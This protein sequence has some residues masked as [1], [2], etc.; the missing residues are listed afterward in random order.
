M[1]RSGRFSALVMLLAAPSMWGQADRGTIRGT[2]TDPA[3]SGVAQ[4][5]VVAV[6]VATGTQNATLSTES[7][8]YN[9]PALPAGLYR[10]Q[11]EAQGFKKLLRENVR[12]N[13]GVIV[14]LDLQFELGATAETIT[15]SAEAPQ[16]A[17]ESSDLR[18][19]INP[20]TFADL[21]L[22]S[23]TGRNPTGLALLS[24]GTR[25]GGNSAA[26]SFYTSFNGGQILSGEVELEG[27][28]VLFPPSPGQPDA[29][30]SMAPEAIQEVSIVT[31]GAS[32]EA[33]GGTGMTR[34]AIRS[35]TNNFH[36]N[37]YEFLRNDKLDANSFF[38]NRQGLDRAPARR[39]EFGGSLGG[40]IWIPG[41]WKGTDKAFFFV[42]IQ[43]FRLRQTPAASTVT[44]PTV[45]F[46]QGDFSS[47][48]DAQGK[49][50]PIYDPAT[51]RP[52]GAGGFI[53]DVFPLNIIPQSRFS[54]VSKNVMKYIPD[55]TLPGNFNN[56]L[57][58]SPAPTDLN[59][60]TYKYDH[61]FTP[62]HSFSFSWTRFNRD[63][64]SGS[65]LGTPEGLL[66]DGINGLAHNTGRMSHDWIITPRIMNH[67]I[68][69]YNR[70]NRSSRWK[71]AREW[72]VE[73]G[74][75]GFWD[76]KCSGPVVSF[77][78]NI[79]GTGY[80]QLGRGTGDPAELD[81]V[82]SYMLSDTLSWVRGSH[83]MKFGFESRWTRLNFGNPTGCG[84]FNFSGSRTGFP[85]NSGLNPAI[86]REQQAIAS[87]DPFASFLLGA[88]DGA[89]TGINYAEAL[90]PRWQY[91][92]GFAQDDIKVRR[93]FTLN[94]GL[95]WDYWLPLLD[96]F[97]NYSMMD[98]T[99]QIP[100]AQGF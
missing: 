98:P 5:K 43:G 95:R 23:G 21:P 70:R 88:A 20:A 55:P 59:S 16:L 49:L 46:K 48:K 3:A 1:L 61:R 57:G 39:N 64:I 100:A 27:L 65:L 32:A 79:Y 4:A 12:V 41:V 38:R 62:H 69:G 33:R 36:G 85:N 14:A 35:G 42:N 84:G 51:T 28:S 76:G 54:T 37:L 24:P 30:V 68:F 91:Y 74:L 29:I 10:V 26:G 2:L 15:V 77:G 50:V 18:T 96:K 45:A 13:A 63:S 82:D 89:G 90:A 92:S 8:N 11:A 97:D 99:F 80:Q 78:G 67:A 73:L 58:T 56:F 53:R 94:V 31:A 17:K 83:N 47:L 86:P 72:N 60:S 87:G 52:D 66:G 93:N 44:V 40:P 19:T 7:G 22:V 81:A 6:N 34:Y 75:Q 9:I 25:Q 71:G